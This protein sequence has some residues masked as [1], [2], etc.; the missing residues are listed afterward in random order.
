MATD[1]SPAASQRKIQLRLA[2]LAMALIIAG[3]IVIGLDNYGSPQPWPKLLS[4]SAIGIGNIILLI[5]IMLKPERR[6]LKFV[7]IGI[8]LAIIVSYFA[9]KVSQ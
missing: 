3:F 8:S 5:S 4:K 2:N 9:F 7:L 6:V 1:N